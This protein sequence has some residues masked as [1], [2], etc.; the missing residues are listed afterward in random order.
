[1][2]KMSNDYEA[3]KLL[4][5]PI[6]ISHDILIFVKAMQWCTTEISGYFTS[7][8]NT[9]DGNVVTEFRFSD[10]D[11]AMLFKLTWSGSENFLDLEE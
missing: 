5:G 4:Y 7:G 10:S 11:D 8:I 2:G 3:D 1:M 9:I 6:R